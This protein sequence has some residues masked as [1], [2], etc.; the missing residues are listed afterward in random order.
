MQIPFGLL[1]LIGCLLIGIYIVSDYLLPNVICKVIP[2]NSIKS[3]MGEYNSNILG[4]VC[5]GIG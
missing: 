4:E 1:I 2:H 5:S 3:Q